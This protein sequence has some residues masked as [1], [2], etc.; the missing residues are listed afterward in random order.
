MTDIQR[1]KLVINYISFEPLSIFTYRTS[2][3]IKIASDGDCSPPFFRTG[4]GGENPNLYI[5]Q[6]IAFHTQI[7]KKHGYSTLLDHMPENHRKI[8][9]RRG[10][11]P[12]YYL[13][14]GAGKWTLYPRV[15]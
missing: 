9:E 7:L 3:F 10:R 8:A 14:K 6:R 12:E 1:R 2:I 5:L 11:N 13:K 4:L 15:F